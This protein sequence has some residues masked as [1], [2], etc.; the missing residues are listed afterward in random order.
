MMRLVELL[1]SDSQPVTRVPLGIAKFEDEFL[2]AV[3]IFVLDLGLVTPVY[4]VAMHAHIKLTRVVTGRVW[5]I[6]A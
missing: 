5:A 6:M 3:H 4:H 1:K 2:L